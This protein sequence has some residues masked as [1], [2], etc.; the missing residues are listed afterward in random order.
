MRGRLVYRTGG[1]GDMGMA[2]ESGDQ[3]GGAPR[4]VVYRMAKTGPLVACCAFLL[5]APAMAQISPLV[6]D[7]TDCAHAYQRNVYFCQS[8]A[9]RAAEAEVHRLNLAAQHAGPMW[10]DVRDN[11]EAWKGQHRTPNAML[12]DIHH[13]YEELAASLQRLTAATKEF[14]ARTVGR[15]DLGRACLAAPGLAFPTFMMACQ[16]TSVSGVA[17]GLLAQMQRWDP[18]G[19]PDSREYLV[20]VPRSFSAVILEREGPEPDDAKAASEP[21]WHPVAW[22]STAGA[23]MS[24]PILSKGPQG[25]FITVPITSD[26]SAGISSDVVIRRIGVLAWREVDAQSW[27]REMDKRVP[28]PLIARSSAA[29]DLANLSSQVDLARPDDSNANPTGGKADVSLAVR[30]DVLVIDGIT[31]TPGPK[32]SLPRGPVPGR[33]PTYP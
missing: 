6:P 16:V 17:P 11:Y 8:T 31:F 5:S 32:P 13:D 22:V 26:G 2:M 20:Q 3:A 29:L 30:D 1:I 10:V 23:T 12:S 19:G 4:G 21:A 25:I 18:P 33:R 14:E 9:W 7:I 15:E 27:R 28:H 24:P